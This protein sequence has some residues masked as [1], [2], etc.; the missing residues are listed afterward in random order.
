M[1]ASDQYLPQNS[2]YCNHYLVNHFYKTPPHLIQEVFLAAIYEVMQALP[3][4]LR[5]PRL[6]HLSHQMHLC[7]P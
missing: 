1:C 2:S 7:G 4:R 6:L 3:V 5:L